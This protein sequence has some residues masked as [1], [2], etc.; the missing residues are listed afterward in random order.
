MSDSDSEIPKPKKF[1]DKDS[2]TTL[3]DLFRNQEWLESKTSETIELWNECDNTK[4]Q[5]LV[6]ELLYR[7]QM[8]TT[9]EIS[10]L[11][12]NIAKVICEEWN[13]KQESTYLVAIC[14]D[15]K[16]DGS[17][18][19]LQAVKS[20]FAVYDWKEDQFINNLKKIQE[21]PYT[22]LEDK[23]I[24]VFDDFIGTGNTAVRKIT[25]LKNRLEKIGIESNIKLIAL[26]SMQEAEEKI[27]KIGIDYYVP[28]ILGKGISDNYPEEEIESKIEVMKTLERK[29]CESINNISLPSLGY[30]QSEALFSIQG[31]NTPNN[32]FPIFWWPMDNSGKRRRTI[33]KRLI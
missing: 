29:L 23:V 17:Q 22:I 13:L 24:I 11:C 18:Y 3:F 12:D 33:L 30:G 15:S 19:F 6:T 7:F 26:A 32:V 1:M 20:S 14:N 4:Q 9:K 28:V 25:W 5:D 21:I 31:L 8:L 16:P 10:K 27:N 2:F